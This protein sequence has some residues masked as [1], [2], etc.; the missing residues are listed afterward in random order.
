QAAG[1]L[2]LPTA[3]PQL[4]QIGPP[5][6]RLGGPAGVVAPGVG[7]AA[8]LPGRFVTRPQPAA[9]PA[10][11]IQPGVQSPAGAIQPGTPSPARTIAPRRFGTFAPAP[12]P[13]APPGAL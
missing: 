10:G 9:G 13:A 8:V 2:P 5:P 4:P 3:L 6:P 11:A 1:R 7:P 12:V